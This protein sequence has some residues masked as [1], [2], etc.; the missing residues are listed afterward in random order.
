MHDVYN[1]FWN[2]YNVAVKWFSDWK[3]MEAQVREDC[4]AKN[5]RQG[6]VV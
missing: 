2:I 4:R 6:E 1:V 5:G 3:V